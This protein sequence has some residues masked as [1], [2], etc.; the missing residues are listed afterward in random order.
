MVIIL[1]SALM[2]LRVFS[3]EQVDLMGGCGKTKKA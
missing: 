1:Y 3:E 2:S